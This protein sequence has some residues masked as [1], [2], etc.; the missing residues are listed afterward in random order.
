MARPDSA[1]FVAASFQLAGARGTALESNLGIAAIWMGLAL[2]GL[3]KG[4]IDPYQYTVLVT[5][6]IASAVLPT[7][8]AQ[9]FFRPELEPLVAL[10]IP[11]P[12]LPAGAAPA[13]ASANTA[14]AP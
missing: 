6:V 7:L 8:V 2:F 4:F 11:P 1:V 12:D 5:V 10:E 13:T 14:T 9:A 3:R